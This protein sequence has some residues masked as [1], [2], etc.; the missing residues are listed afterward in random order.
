[1]RLY[2]GTNMEFKTI[3]IRKGNPYKDFG[4]GFYLTDIYFQ[5]E[6]MARKKAKIMGGTGIVQTYEFQETLLNSTRLN[7]LVFEKATKEWAEF[8][9]KNRSRHFPVHHHGY[10]IVIGPIADDGVAYLLNRYEEGS[11]TLEELAKELE[12]KKL[13]RQFFFGT[14]PAIQLLKRIS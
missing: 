5:A 1:M 2:H 6:A 14:E 9:Y 3:D 11:F 8:I 13:N 7:I 10:D 12:Y 4:Q